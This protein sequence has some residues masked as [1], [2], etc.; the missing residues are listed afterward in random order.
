M[1]R[2][3]YRSLLVFIL[4]LLSIAQLKAQ[5]WANEW[6]HAF[7]QEGRKEWKPEFT[8]RGRAGFVGSDP[9][10]EFTGGVRIDDKRTLGLMVSQS[11][12]YYDAVPAVGYHINTAIYMRRYFHLGG[13]YDVIAFYSDAAIGAK[14]KYKGY[15]RDIFYFAAWEPGIR[16][17]LIYGNIHIFVGPT[18]ALDCIGFHAG[19]GF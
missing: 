16:M 1:K 6:K 14:W 10:L 17:K 11:K 13:E 4:P 7:S 5:S 9:C 18:L 12:T 8:V 15:G 19:L 2:I 3:F